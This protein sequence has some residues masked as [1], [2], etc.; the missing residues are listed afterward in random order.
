MMSE[1]SRPGQPENS[2]GQGPAARTDQRIVEEPAH[3]FC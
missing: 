1:L 2:Q 3:V